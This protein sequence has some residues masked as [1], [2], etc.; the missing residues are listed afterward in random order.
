MIEELFKNVSKTTQRNVI[1]ILKSSQMN[2]TCENCSFIKR[3]WEPG[4]LCID[5]ERGYTPES[6]PHD[7]VFNEGKA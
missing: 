1:A 3:C 6:D 7:F 4:E 2:K 5:Y